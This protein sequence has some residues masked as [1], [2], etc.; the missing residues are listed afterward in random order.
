MSRVRAQR[1]LLVVLLALPAAA[2]GATDGPGRPARPALRGAALEALPPALE[3][4]RF[5][6]RARLHAAPP[7]TVG[8][9]MRALELR[10]VLA[11]KASVASCPLPGAL[12]SDGFES[13]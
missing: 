13:P 7:A 9:R 11:P 5:R 8:G 10:A 3:G 12:F 4:G 2:A 6:L 1:A